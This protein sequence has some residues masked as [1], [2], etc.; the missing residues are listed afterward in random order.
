MDSGLYM[1]SVWSQCLT[2][3]LPSLKS[4][5]LSVGSL[6]NQTLQFEIS[7]LVPPEWKK[8]DLTCDDR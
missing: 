7:R 4:G 8:N 6:T 2:V 1:D 3:L 5:C